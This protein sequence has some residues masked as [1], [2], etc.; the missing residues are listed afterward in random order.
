MQF[1]GGNEYFES[2]VEAVGQVQVFLCPLSL[3]RI[4]YLRGLCSGGVNRIGF[5]DPVTLHIVDSN[6]FEKLQGLIVLNP[7]RD[8]FELHGMSDVVDGLDHRLVNRVGKHVPDQSAVDFQVIKWNVFQITKR[9]QSA[10][11]VIQRETASQCFQ[12]S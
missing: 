3:S 6:F 8:S 11:E 7:F 5:C 10:A 4:A 1:T 12:C 9:R 2:N